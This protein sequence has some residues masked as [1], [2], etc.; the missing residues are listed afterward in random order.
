VPEAPE[1]AIDTLTASP[2]EAAHTLLLKLEAMG[3]IR[4]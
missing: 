4:N 2:D 1:A 3:L